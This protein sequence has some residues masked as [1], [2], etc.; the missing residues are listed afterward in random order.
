MCA[1][2]NLIII[3]Q[4]NLKTKLANFSSWFL[5]LRNSKKGIK[6][7]QKIFGNFSIKKK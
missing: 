2:E 3:K 4:L 1:K 7:S 6:N 5:K